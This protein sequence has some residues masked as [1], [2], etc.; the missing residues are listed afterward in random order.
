MCFIVGVQYLQHIFV[1]CGKFEGHCVNLQLPLYLF[2]PT[3]KWHVVDLL[4]DP[5][6]QDNA[7]INIHGDLPQACY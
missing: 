5:I 7:G 2:F 1:P 6:I 3:G 4:T